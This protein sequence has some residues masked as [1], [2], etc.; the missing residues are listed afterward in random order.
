MTTEPNDAKLAKLLKAYLRDTSMMQLATSSPDGKPWVSNVWFVFDDKFNIYWVSSRSVRHSV[1]VKANPH[2]AASIC[3]VNTPLDT[4]L[5]AVQVEG[6]V[7]VIRNPIDIA[8]ISKMFVAR[9]I[10]SSDK[11][12]KILSSVSSIYKLTSARYVI[13]KPGIVK[14]SDTAVYKPAK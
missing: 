6:S 13:F 7:K 5:G 3:A 10:I 1:E 4:K 14:G 9:G 12:T 8:R 2:V 11:L